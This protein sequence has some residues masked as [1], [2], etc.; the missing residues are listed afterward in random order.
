MLAVKIDR[1]SKTLLMKNSINN[2][3]IQM[4]LPVI[5]AN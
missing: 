2:T 5:D 1:T 4:N 3:N